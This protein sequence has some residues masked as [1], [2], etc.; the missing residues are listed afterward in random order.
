MF[1]VIKKL[2]L[3]AFFYLIFFLY[4][5]K[6]LAL[7]NKNLVE[8]SGILNVAPVV[9]NNEVDDHILKKRQRG[10]RRERGRRRKLGIKKLKR[11]VSRINTRMSLLKQQIQSLQKQLSSK[12]ELITTTAS[13]STMK[14]TKNAV[15]PGNPGGPGKP[16]NS[17]G[18]NNPGNSGGTKKPPQTTKPSKPKP[19][20]P[21]KPSRP[22]S[23]II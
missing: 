13:T 16:G 5:F 1:S 22:K 21:S 14:T 6:T 15:K 10:R 18:S 23:K 19:S 8:H 12:M 11:F 9:L 2:H 20:K 7:N 3:P 4:F 17:N